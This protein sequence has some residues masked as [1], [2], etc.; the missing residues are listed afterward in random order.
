M[1]AGSAFV[2]RFS[3]GL[4][5]QLFQ[6]AFARM[7]AHQSSLP[8]LYDLSWY[9]GAVGQSRQDRPFLLPEYHIVARECDAREYA[10][11]SPTP[12]MLSGRLKA[13][14]RLQD[15]CLGRRTF[16]ESG[17]SVLESAT[18]YYPEW[19]QTGSPGFA[20]GFFA[21]HH[22]PDAIRP[23][24]LEE[25]QMK[26]PM[27]REELEITQQVRNEES[28]CVCFRRGDFAKL[29]ELGIMEEG[30]YERAF[31]LIKAR[32]RNPKFY[33]FSDEPDLAYAALSKLGVEHVEWPNAPRT[34]P[35]TLRLMQ[36]CKHFILANSTYGWWAAWLGQTEQTVVVRPSIWFVGL[37]K[38]YAHLFPTRWLAAD[39]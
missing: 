2:I 6:Y 14:R 39:L 12:R 18:S 17:T 4:G 11:L 33:V 35:E 29:P 27:S 1:P 25:F 3:D 5:N 21:S 28:V 16:Y 24:L 23:L 22:Y 36:K 9:T 32:V 30:Y 20:S 8:L 31:A 34:A 13:L 19:M 7:H 37:N 38:P 10:R 26:Q 15:W